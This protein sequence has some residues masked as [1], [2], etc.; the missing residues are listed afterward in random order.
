MLASGEVLI[1]SPGMCLTLH[2]LREEEE[3]VV[4]DGS[5]VSGARQCATAEQVAIE[6]LAL[7]EGGF[8]TMSGAMMTAAPPAVAATGDCQ[9]PELS[10]CA[11]GGVF[12]PDVVAGDSQPLTQAAVER[13]GSC[14]L[15]SDDSVVAGGVPIPPWIA[16]ASVT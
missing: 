1:Q 14:R 11:V 16:V 12:K 15:P 5:S 4:E 13:S 8:G 3:E 7:K 10:T 2:S 6:Q 9:Q